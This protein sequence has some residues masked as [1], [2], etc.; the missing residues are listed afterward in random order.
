MFAVERDT[1]VVVAGRKAF[2]VDDHL[3]VGRSLVKSGV[4]CQRDFYARTVSKQLRFNDVIAA[5]ALDKE[6]QQQALA[7]AETTPVLD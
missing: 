3:N 2:G 4:C 5:V 7:F 6:K 1:D